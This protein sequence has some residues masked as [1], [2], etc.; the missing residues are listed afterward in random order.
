MILRP[1]YHY[2]KNSPKCGLP[3]QAETNT[4]GC[5][6]ASEAKESSGYLWGLLRRPNSN[7]T[8]RNDILPC[9]CEQSEAISPK[10]IRQ[11]YLSAGDW[12]NAVAIYQSPI[13]RA[14]CI[15]R[16]N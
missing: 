13:N 3:Y 2:H 4:R 12:M 7:G 9:H 15:A 10:T 6:I 16:F 11:Y 1:Y 5:V 8:L 14:F